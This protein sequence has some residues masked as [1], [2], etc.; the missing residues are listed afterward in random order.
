M[1]TVKVYKARNGN[2]DKRGKALY[3]FVLAHDDEQAKELAKEAFGHCPGIPGERGN[4][5][6]IHAIIE[7]LSQPVASA[8]WSLPIDV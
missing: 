8:V 6:R 2:R 7:D 4:R 3:V 1:D 5:I